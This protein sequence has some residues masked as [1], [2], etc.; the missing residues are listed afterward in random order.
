[1]KLHYGCFTTADVRSLFGVTRS[2]PRRRFQV[3]T[4]PV[5]EIAVDEGHVHS[6]SGTDIGGS[7]E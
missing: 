5:G 3:D 4:V 7:T 2:I 6:E 1:M